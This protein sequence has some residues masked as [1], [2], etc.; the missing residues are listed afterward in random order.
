MAT[1]KETITLPTIPLIP[2]EETTSGLQEAE[3]QAGEVGLSPLRS[4][5]QGMAQA[6]EGGDVSA[7][8][9]RTEK[10]INEASDEDA[11]AAVTQ[12]MRLKVVVERVYN[13]ANE[14][15]LARAYKK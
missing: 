15:N 6:A 11:L 13:V 3:L 1:K 12:L 14:A 8:V 2:S 10:V 4:L 5:L 9:Q 7:L